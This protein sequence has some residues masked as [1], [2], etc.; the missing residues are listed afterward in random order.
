[1]GHAGAVDLDP[2]LGDDAV[3]DVVDDGVDL[4]DVLGVVGRAPF[5]RDLVLRADLMSPDPRGIRAAARSTA[6]PERTWSRKSVT[7]RR[8]TAAPLMD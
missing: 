4:A 6:R 1:V 7:T 2:V 8:V 3:L 5:D